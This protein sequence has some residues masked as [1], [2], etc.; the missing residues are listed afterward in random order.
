METFDA[1][2]RALNVSVIDL[3][4]DTDGNSITLPSEVVV[5]KEDGCSKV[6]Y[7]LPLTEETYKF[8]ANE[9]NV[10]HFEPR[11]KTVIGRWDKLS[12]EEKD[13]I[14]G[15]SEKHDDLGS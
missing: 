1:L 3:W 10:D 6:K 12:E 5:E 13:C 7:S 4:V 2:L 8:L 14:V 11:L 15:Y 9:I